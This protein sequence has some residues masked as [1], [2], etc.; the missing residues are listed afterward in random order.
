MADQEWFE[1]GHDGSKVITL[2][3]RLFDS[4]SRAVPDARSFFQRL[5]YLYIYPRCADG[6]LG[7]YCQGGPRTD[8]IEASDVPSRLLSRARS[9]AAAACFNAEVVMRVVLA[10]IPLSSSA[11]GQFSRRCLVAFQPR[12]RFRHVSPLRNFWRSTIRPQVPQGTGR[13]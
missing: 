3:S 8:K 13:R 5:Q 11:I 12:C 10:G 1:D 9:R 6:L 7:H 4:K 2:S